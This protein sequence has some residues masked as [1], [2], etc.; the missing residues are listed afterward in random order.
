[1]DKYYYL[2]FPELHPIPEYRGKTPMSPLYNIES[3][4]LNWKVGLEYEPTDDSHLHWSFARNDESRLYTDDDGNTPPPRFSVA[5]SI[6][7]YYKNA[8]LTDSQ[9]DLGRGFVM[10]LRYSIV[11]DSY[12]YTIA[13]NRD[14]HR[15]SQTIRSGI[16]WKLTRTT[17]LFTN[18]DLGF[19]YTARE[20]SSSLPRGSN[21]EM[22]FGG[23]SRIAS[24]VRVKYSVTF[25]RYNQ[26]TVDYSSGTDSLKRSFSI[27]PTFS[28]SDYWNLKFS[29]DFSEQISFPVGGE[30]G[31]RWLRHSN[32]INAIINLTP[33]PN[34]SFE[35][36]YNWDYSSSQ[37][38][39]VSYSSEHSIGLEISYNVF[40]DLIV[41]FDA[42]YLLDEYDTDDNSFNI[43]VNLRSQLF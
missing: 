39:S 24:G 27:E 16:K 21:V 28:I 18:L 6:Y 12:V 5:D 34:L 4:S 33:T 1:M 17:D 25:E 41:A 2:I 22:E 7:D 9:L 38:T 13:E 23:E 14:V 19:D 11:M 15:L 10:T 3:E 8:M 31:T 30:S 26:R 43:G 35:F 36:Y 20:S 42:N 29:G 32:D 37:Y 40:G